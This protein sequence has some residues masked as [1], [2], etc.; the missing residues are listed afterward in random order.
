M[1]S[2]VLAAGNG[3]RFQG[4]GYSAIKPLLPMPDG[5]PLLAW[6]RER[7]PAGRQIIIAR[8]GDM[9]ALAPHTRGMAAVWLAGT[10][11]GPLSSARAVV[12]HLDMDDELLISYCDTL[13]PSGA[14][15]FVASARTV[16]AVT[17]MVVFPS[18]DPRYGYWDGQRV[19]EKQAASPWA[20]S[21]LFYFD[22]ARIFSER[23]ARDY[24]PGA[25]LPSLMDIA[26]HYYEADVID[27]GTPADY[28][29]FLHACAEPVR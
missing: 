17:A 11:D 28:E 12:P 4:A 9:A 5:R 13:L 29:A 21:G 18:D 6:V 23:A 2:V 19:I 1:L 27:V 3:Q 24:P 22:Q 7:L 26:T 8:R 10:T 16:R 25:G 20:V 15:A 14:D